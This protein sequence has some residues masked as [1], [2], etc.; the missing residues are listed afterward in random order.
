MSDPDRNAILQRR[1]ALIAATVASIGIACATRQAIA[2]LSPMLPEPSEGGTGELPAGMTRS[3]IGQDFGSAAS[4]AG[5]R[6]GGTR[7]AGT[8]DAGTRDA[9]ARPLPCLSLSGAL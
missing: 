8:R 6:D 2:C 4:D 5:A 9:G 3:A 1:A 7:D